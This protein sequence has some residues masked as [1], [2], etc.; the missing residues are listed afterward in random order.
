MEEIINVENVCN[1]GNYKSR[2]AVRCEECHRT[3]QEKRM[4]RL[5]N[6]NICPECGGRKD[7]RATLCSKCVLPSRIEFARKANRASADARR[8]TDE[9]KGLV[10]PDCGGRK[11]SRSSICSTCYSLRLKRIQSQ[12]IERKRKHDA[13]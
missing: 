6:E 9:R 5:S 3:K 8:K 10:C 11:S 1:C 13:A 2:R 7:R 12:Q 4:P